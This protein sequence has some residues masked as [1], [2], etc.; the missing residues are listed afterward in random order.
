MAALDA[1]DTEQPTA[2]TG[3]AAVPTSIHALHTLGR[4][5][6]TD[7]GAMLNLDDLLVRKAR[8]ASRCSRECVWPGGHAGA[9]ARRRR[10]AASVPN[11]D[12][13]EDSL[14]RRVERL[15]KAARREIQ[16]RPNGNG[17]NAPAF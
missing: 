9:G 3:A 5:A 4:A 10:G 15:A 6:Q 8:P 1:D 16:S 13:D 12:P 14:A 7:I 17:A 11:T 2:D